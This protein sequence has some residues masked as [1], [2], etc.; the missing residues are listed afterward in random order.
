MPIL[1][2]GTIH[3]D[4]ITDHKATYCVF[5]FESCIPKTYTRCVWL[6]KEGNYEN[7]KNEIDNEDWGSLFEGK[8]VDTI[9]SD[10][11]DKLMSIA[12]N[13]I[14]RKNVVIRPYDKAWFNSDIRREIRIRDRLRKIYRRTLNER[15]LNKYKTQR[16]KIN[17]MKKKL[18]E[19]YI[20]GM[21]DSLH[22]Y[23][24]TDIKMYWKLINSLIKGDNQTYELPTM[25]YDGNSA[26]TD[27]SK[28]NLFNQYFCSVSDNVDDNHELPTF[29]QRTDADIHDVH[30]TVGEVI[31]QIKVLDPKKACGPDSF[32]HILLRN[33]CFSIAFPLTEIFNRSIQTGT[34]PSQWKHA[35]V[36]P[37][38]KK[39]DKSVPNNYRPISLLSCIGKLFERVMFRHIY[40]H[41]HENDL[42][43]D[44][45][46]GFRPGHSTVSQLIEIYHQICLA[47]DNRDFSCF[48]FCDISKAFDR[49]WIKGLIHKL[50][51][52]GIKGQLLSWL[53]DYLTD[54]TQ[55]VK[56]KNSV[57]SQ[58][59]INSGV[60]QGSVLGPLLFLIYINDLPDGLK[61][62]TRLFA[63]DTSNAHTSSD[64]TQIQNDNNEDLK[65]IIKW[66]KSW[67]VDFNPHKT[68]IMIF[69][70]RNYS[71]STID[72]NFD[73]QTIHPTKE[74]V[75]L[76]ITFSDDAKWSK[77]VDYIISRVSKQISVLRKL[78]YQLSR[79]F[80]SNIYTTFIRPTFEYACEVWDNLTV[81]DSDRL[82]KFQLEAGRIVT[83]LPSYSSRAAIYF[84]TGWETLKQRRQNRKLTL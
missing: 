3:V 26:F 31:D 78:K 19:E 58:G 42:L 15:D 2:S 80:L 59:I 67:L 47:I 36:L 8:H 24:R 35:H 84:E 82:E 50:D 63:D 17:N 79:T 25:T 40:N 70:S 23:K 74:H 39:G 45:Q 75:H 32:S 9:V 16:N 18:K 43:Y 57:S 12:E 13:N 52:Y 64:I 10:F 30:I 1:E 60:P 66:A 33:T 48:T 65:Q 54:R 53:S 41:L 37:I 28:A 56:L 14:P 76:G 69:G 6:Y 72:F 7:I 61:G 5:N 11:S 68:K 81:Y 34:Y 20:I 51:K 46:A 55:Q 27:E 49:V 38:F 44:L 21:N 83:G 73:G 29:D 4:N 77:H 71:D 62:L 22:E